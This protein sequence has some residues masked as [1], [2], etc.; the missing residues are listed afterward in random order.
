[1]PRR[2]GDRLIVEGIVRD[3]TAEV[4]AEER[5]REAARTDR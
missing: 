1:M 2:E 3:A 4:G 5:L